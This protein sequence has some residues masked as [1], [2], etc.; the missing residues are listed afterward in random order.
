MRTLAV[1]LCILLALLSPAF[2]MAQV[3][4][5]AGTYSGNYSGGDSGTWTAIIS[6]NG[7][8]TA[9]GNSSQDGPFTASGQVS[10]NGSLTMTTGGSTSNG[11]VFT[12]MINS[13]TGIM[14]GTWTNSSSQQSGIWKGTLTK[15]ST[16]PNTQ[17]ISPISFTPSI[18]SIGGTATVSASSS[19]GLAVTF[20]SLTPNICTITSSKSSLF[21]PD[22]YTV[23]GV[24]TGTCTIAANQAGG[25]VFLGGTYSAAPQVTQNISVG[26]FTITLS[27]S[28]TGS[29]TLT[30]ADGS[31]NCGGIC[32]ASYSSG[33]NVTLTAAPTSGSTFAGWGGACSGTGMCTVTMNAVQNVTATFNLVPF[34]AVTT[35]VTNGFITTPTATVTTTVT[36]TP[37]DVGK[38]ESVFITAWVPSG[39]LTTS[40]QA[41]IASYTTRQVKPLGTTQ[42]TTFVLVQLTPSGWTPVVNGQL[43]PYVSNV[44]SDQASAL[45]ILDNT[46]TASL[47][48]SQFCVGYGTSA[49]DMT[50]AGRMQLVATVAN[51]NAT[52]SN[53]G[54]CNVALPISDARVFAYAVA[55]YASL[56]AGNPTPGLYLQYDYRYY[57]TYQNFLAVD[58]LGA[59]WLMGPTF[60]PAN[61]PIRIGPIE[62]FRSVITSWEGTQ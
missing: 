7:V 49:S 47:L 59:V 11:G 62:N 8:L 61:T 5:Y 6:S 57:P 12:G 26:P 54:S 1:R 14:S 56:F 27:K 58:N 19:S 15:A 60:A 52:K 13:S 24:A 53:S 40:Q 55:N 4:N 45:K 42:S 35:G 44:T 48:G 51:P 41:S 10:S 43:I 25:A 23:M 32:N 16:Q 39:S 29:G 20:T 50:S 31:L 33:S 34:V 9:T 3:A 30:S 37:A 21:S 22:T 28:G 17:I 46:S 2:A 36:F 38:P 18:L